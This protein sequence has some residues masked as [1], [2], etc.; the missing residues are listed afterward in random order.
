ML[1]QFL[2]STFF[3][4]T[5]SLLLHLSLA[6]QNYRMEQ[7]DGPETP[8]ADSLFN[9][10]AF[11][12]ALSEYHKLLADYPQESTFYYK[13]GITYLYGT[14]NVEKAVKHLSFASTREVP[15][16]VY[17][18]LGYAHQL[19]YSFDRAI[20]YYKRF[21]INKASINITQQHIENLLGQCESGDFMLKYIYQPKVLDKRRV[22]VDEMHQFIVTQSNHTS[23][24]PKPKD[25]ITTT[26]AKQKGSSYVYFPINPKP[27]DKLI[28][29]SYGSTT[30]FGKDL[31]II[32]MLDNG[33]WSK[34]K[35][36]GDNIN[37]NL[38]EDFPYLAPDGV[39]LYFASKGHYSMGGYDIYRSIYNSS[40]SQWSTP[41]NLG[42]P[43]SSPYDDFMFVPNEDET[44]ATFVTNRSSLSDSIDVVL[45]EL[46]NNPIRR[47]I[48][49]KETIREIARLDIAKSKENTSK[50]TLGKSATPSTKIQSKQ[51]TASFS[52]VENDPEY[53][54]ALSLGFSQQLKADSL[55][56]KLEALREKFD[57]VT[58]ANQRIALEKQV[59][60][61]EDSLLKAQR[62][63]DIYFAK[64]SKIE[65]EFLVGKRKPIDNPQS[66]FSTDRPDF[67]YQAQYATTV[68]QNDELVK[69]SKIELMTS[70][71]E[72]QRSDVLKVKQKS[73]IEL[74]DTDSLTDE[75][76]Y[77]VELIGKMNAFNKTLSE[78]IVVKK[79]LYNNCISVAM[80]KAGTN[81]NEQ[82][83]REIEIAKSHFRS[84]TAIRNNSVEEHKIESEYEALLLDEL[85]VLRLEIAFAKLWGINNFEQQTLSKVL[86]LERIAFGDDFVKSQAKTT[87]TTTQAIVKDEESGNRPSI[88]RIETDIP[89]ASDIEFASE[90]ESSFQLVEGEDYYKSIKDIPL[91]LPL[92]QGV[93]YKIQLAAFSKPIDLSIFKRMFPLWAEPIND[94]KITKY[95]AGSFRLLSAA[96]KALSTVRSKGFKD[97]FI[98]AWHNGRSV[99]LARAKSLEGTEQQPVQGNSVRIDIE[100]DSKY[101]IIQIG[102][103]PGKLP[104]DITHTVRTLATGKD[105][106]RKSNP[107]GGYTY[108][109]GSYSN[110]SEANRI[111]DNIVASGIKSA[112]VIAVDTDN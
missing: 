12:K 42:F 8:L 2:G 84:A 102:E 24:I 106:V 112:L 25:L 108:S 7:F 82:V 109:V 86:K 6:G 81:A 60:A 36:L 57:F 61:V 48:N 52:D 64:A 91:H 37:T 40:V 110:A 35:D 62:N 79:E 83:K 16:A 20:E 90:R 95:Y 97:A 87:K 14:R 63:A 92:P 100:S 75:A 59:V 30:T 1:K 33:L 89:I 104:D 32:E 15:N 99:Q 22:K 67:L 56:L 29:S 111:K 51:N 74:L 13:L 85:A 103:Y 11:D 18:H 9:V 78:Y 101:Y 28:Y 34:P 45:V 17:Y 21:T 107:K 94:D 50:T 76:P 43:F 3:I 65:Q 10:G 73:N 5:F 44:L 68:F 88:T 39:T 105:I 77:N 27:G 41:E 66:S 46:D 31:Y 4:L 72:N 69:L 93:I 26:D 96:E 80:M 98:V 49:S 58:T 19:N 55:R 71:I 53:S 47:S 70:K 54:R 23:L 38:D